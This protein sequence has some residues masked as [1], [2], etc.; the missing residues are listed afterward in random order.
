MAKTKNKNHS[1]IESL[2]GY[3]RELEKTVRS[4]QKQLR[5]YEKYDRS[6]DDEVSKDSED[7][8]LE[9]VL[10]TKPCTECGKGHVIETL[11]IMGKIYGTCNVCDYKSRMK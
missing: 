7:T 10:L 1:E 8:H 11:E 6:Q 5:Q 9:K 3:V 4:Q 2:R